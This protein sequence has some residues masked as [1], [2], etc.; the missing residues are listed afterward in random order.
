MS[1]IQ[2]ATAGGGLQQQAPLTTCELSEGTKHGDPMLIGL[3]ASGRVV[4]RL[5]ALRDRALQGSHQ[6]EYTLRNDCFR[7]TR[8]TY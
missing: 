6:D 5:V 3:D 1:H 2:H 7:A 4:V 8:G